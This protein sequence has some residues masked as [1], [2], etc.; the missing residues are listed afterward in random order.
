MGYRLHGIIHYLLW[1]L[2]HLLV[3]DYVSQLVEAKAIKTNDAKTIDF[4]KSNIFCMFGV[5]KVLISNQGSHFCNRVM[6]TLLEKYRVVDRVATVYHPQTNGQDEVFNRE[7]KKLLQKMVNLS[8]NDWS[9]LLGDALWA[10]RTA[11]WTP[12]GMSPYRFVFSKACHL[13]VG[14]EHQAYWVIKKCN[15]AYNKAGQERKLQL[16][17]FKVS[18]KVLLFNSRLKL[19][20]DKLRS[21]SKE[22]LNEVK[23]AR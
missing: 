5:L 9:R 6:A 19:I 3:I 7:I 1:K 10:H 11:Y 18:Q 16:K 20:A 22:K 2:L 21:R 17:E 14:I 23:S 8:R 13:L 12:L 15:M 4:V